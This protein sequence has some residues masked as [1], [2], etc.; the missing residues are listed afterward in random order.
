[1]EF[2]G[3][4][5]VDGTCKIAM[6]DVDEDIDGGAATVTDKD[7]SQDP[8]PDFRGGKREEHFWFLETIAD[9][10]N[11]DDDNEEDDNKDSCPVAATGEEHSWLLD[12]LGADIGVKG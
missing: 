2:V 9:D 1:M 7:D 11:E 6:W 4:F 12:I 5:Y 8:R 10:I 3:T